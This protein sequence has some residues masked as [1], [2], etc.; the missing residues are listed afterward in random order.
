M[1]TLARACD[2]H[3]LEDLDRLSASCEASACACCL[4]TSTI[5]RPTLRIGL[6]AARGSGRSSTSRGR[7]APH[8]AFA[9]L[10]H[11]D[12]CERH[13]AV[14]DPPG[15]VENAHRRIGITDLPEPDSP[16]MPTVSPLAIA[17]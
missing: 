11:V 10:P 17:M 8:V 7:A 3:L 1:V 12:A 13:R 15:A 4:S 16:T 14:G 5:W 9:R 6:S 2:P